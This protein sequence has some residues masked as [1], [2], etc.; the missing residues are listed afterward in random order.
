MKYKN[1]LKIEFKAEPYGRSAIYHVLMYRISPNQN[2]IYHEEHTFLGFK[3]KVKKKVDTSWHRAVQYLN[4]PLSERY[5][6]PQTNPVLLENIEEFEEWKTNCKTM[7]DF[8]A[9]LD[10]INTKEIEDWK[11]NR[12]KYL[13]NIKTWR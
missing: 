12:K 4:Y 6:E 2:L 10:E 9:R 13:N 5:S 11:Q 8:F 3:Y 1:D 7:G